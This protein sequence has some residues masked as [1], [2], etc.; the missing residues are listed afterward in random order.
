MRYKVLIVDDSKLARMVMA[1][2]PYPTGLGL[3]RDRQCRRGAGRCFRRRRRHRADRFQHAGSMDWNWLR[4]PQD[5]SEHAGRSCLGQCQN[6]SGAPELDAGFVQATRPTKPLPHFF[7]AALRQESDAV[8]IDAG[9]YRD[10]AGCARRN[11]QHGCRRAASSLG[12]WWASRS[13]CC[14][15][16]QDRNTQLR[17]NWSSAKTRQARRGSSLEGPFSG[18]ALLSSR[19]AK[20]RAGRAIVGDQHSLK[21]SLI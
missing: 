11:R 10:R 7:R 2:L 15:F 19:G 3:G 21:M 5:P 13:S 4:Y 18:R 8:I 17:R 12:Q 14:P 9:E 6:I 20:S 1:R 16:R